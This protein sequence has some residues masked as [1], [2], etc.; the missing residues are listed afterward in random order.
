MMHQ[1]HGWIRICTSSHFCSY[2]ELQTTV[3]LLCVQRH[4]HIGECNG[5][6]IHLWSMTHVLDLKAVIASSSVRL[7]MLKSG[8][9]DSSEG[10]QH[11]C[12]LVLSSNSGLVCALS[13]PADEGQ[14][15]QLEFLTPRLGV[16]L[17]SVT[18]LGDA[19]E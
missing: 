19:K 8:T 1:W 5:G 4:L 18:R 17:V 2:T 12:A 13:E 3:L 14:G 11:T 10:F 15:F 16:L 9:L 7:E 6:C